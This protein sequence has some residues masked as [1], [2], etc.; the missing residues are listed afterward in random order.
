MIGANGFY[1]D[2]TDSSRSDVK[3]S[4][5]EAVAEIAQSRSVIE[6]ANGALMRIYGIPVDRAYKVLTW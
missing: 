3:D 1:I 2:I 4:V 5:D 6:Q